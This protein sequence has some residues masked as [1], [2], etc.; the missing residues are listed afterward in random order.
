MWFERLIRNWK[1]KRLQNP[2]FIHLFDEAPEG[3]YVSLDFETTSL[4]PK[5][6]E[7]ISIGAVKICGNRILTSQKFDR[8]VRPEGKMDRESIK[9]H[10]LRYADLEKA[11]E[12][13]QAIEA[14]L[15]FIGPRPIVG[16][17]IEFDTKILSR[18][19]KKL[20]GTPLPNRIIE[21]SGIYY[22]KKEKLIP[23][24]HIDLRFNTI[25]KD[26]DIPAFGKHS[27]ISDAIMTAMIFLRLQD[28]SALKH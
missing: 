17:Y 22:N 6:A 20:I 4:N 12:A 15:H 24:G 28:P 1:K 11:D 18:Y 7:I 5:T 23:Q 13:Q 8:L 27:A 9:V 21:V 16:Y 19:T 25:M 3:E 10:H 14:L 26:L 2:D